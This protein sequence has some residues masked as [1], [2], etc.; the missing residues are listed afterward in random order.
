MVWGG[1]QIIR[2]V[3]LLEADC[4]PSVPCGRELMEARGYKLSLSHTEVCS[5]FA[6]LLSEEQ[7]Y[8]NFAVIATTKNRLTSVTAR[9]IML[10]GSDKRGRGKN[11][12]R[13]RNNQKATWWHTTASRQRCARPMPGERKGKEGRKKRERAHGRPNISSS[14][15]GKGRVGLS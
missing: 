14:K 3:C 15:S 12:I 9:G 6:I 1:F 7:P 10:P 11:Q 5:L 4:V 2:S 13:K 8:I